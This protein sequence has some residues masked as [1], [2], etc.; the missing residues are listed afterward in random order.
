[1]GRYVI[2]IYQCEVLNLV[3]T[4]QLHEY[5][6]IRQACHLK[7][8]SE[9]FGALAVNKQMHVCLAEEHCKRNY[10]SLFMSMTNHA[11]TGLLRSCSYQNQSKIVRI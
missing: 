1:M 9:T 6:T 10:F 8:Q 4:M 11:D 3:Y 7:L 5:Y 2:R